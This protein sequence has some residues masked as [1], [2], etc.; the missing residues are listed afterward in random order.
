MTGKNKAKLLSLFVISSLAVLLFVGSAA[1]SFS[2]SVETIT[3]RTMPGGFTEYEVTIENFE[4]YDQSMDI[5]LSTPDS[6]NWIITTTP[7]RVTIPANSEESFILTIIP[8]SGVSF[9]SYSVNIRIQSRQDGSMETIRVPISITADGAPAGFVPSVA[10]DVSLPEAH[11]PREPLSLPVQL[12]NR[13]QL[14]ISELYITASSQLFEEQ[15]ME[16]SL[17]PTQEKT[18]YMQFDL[19]PHQAPGEYTIRVNAYYPITE[20]VITENF[21]RLTIDRIVD[22][23]TDYES[24]TNW[25]LT[26]DEI[27]VTNKGNFERI[28]EIDIPAPWYKRIFTSTTPEAEV[29]RIDGRAHYQWAP[30]LE[31]AEEFDILVKTNYRVLVI[32]IALVIILVV[33]YYLFRSPIVI[34]K[35]ASVLG[36]D[37][38]GVS[39]LKIKIFVKNRSGKQI[40]GLSVND[41]LPG[42]IDISDSHHLGSLKP[43][44]VTKTTRKG[45]LLYWNLDSLDSLEER[46]LTYRA[47]AK[48]KIIGNLTLPKARAKFE[49]KNGKERMVFSAKP[50]FVNE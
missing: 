23:D 40:H 10:M 17:G 32:I 31:P 46:I 1:A 4:D 27:T 18:V 19:N 39:E 41:K 43:T 21:P 49:N 6:I 11:D 33:A 2:A 37:E 36:K 38:H 34:M 29:V 45:T 13:N 7:T 14:N 22:T 44:K 8:R 12:R 3:S 42:I 26:K 25:F 16:V 48:L 30:S 20:R 24:K 50:L 9:G 28:T 5:R 35:E 15:Q 47:K